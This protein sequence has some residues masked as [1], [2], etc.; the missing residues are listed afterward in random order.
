M[1][2]SDVASFN[3]T[4]H[5]RVSTDNT[6]APSDPMDLDIESSITHQDAIKVEPLYL[7]R[8]TEAKFCELLAAR[9]RANSPFGDPSRVPVPYSSLLILVDDSSSPGSLSLSAISTTI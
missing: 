1:S 3:E 9:L 7:Q 4:G 5:N 2:E 6:R 8:Q